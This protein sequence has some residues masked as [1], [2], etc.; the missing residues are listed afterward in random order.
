MTAP[1]RAALIAVEDSETRLA[2]RW[3][4]D[5]DGFNVRCASHFA[6]AR[7]EVPSDLLITDLDFGRRPALE[8]L[9]LYQRRGFN[10]W[11]IIVAPEIEGEDLRRALS[12]GV[13]GWIQTPVDETELALALAAMPN[14]GPGE[15]VGVYEA[16]PET[17]A[18]ATREVTA[19]TLRSGLGPATRARIAGSCGELL[20]NVE[21]YAYAGA[22]GPVEVR[23]RLIDSKLELSVRDQG[24]GFDPVLV[25]TGSMSRSLDGGL[26][27]CTALSE[28]LRIDSVLGEGTTISVD[29]CSASV[30]FDDGEMTDLSDLDYLSPREVRRVLREVENDHPADLF[31]LSPALA[32]IIG[33]LLVGPDPRRALQMAIWS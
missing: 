24:I 32:V 19:F 26:A 27:R 23:A 9:S 3:L 21:R 20:E 28:A 15:F 29:F 1:Q 31:H 30:H 25:T 6:A 33:R 16:S 12:L 4:L 2:L 22:N 7:E 8:L 13:R 10:P 17:T 5:R 14:S 18:H 11:T